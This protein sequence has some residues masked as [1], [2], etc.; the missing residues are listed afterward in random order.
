[1]RTEYRS[2][3]NSFIPELAKP[4]ARTAYHSVRGASADARARFMPTPVTT[5]CPPVF[6]IGCGRSGT[7]LLGELIAMHQRVKYLHEPHDLWAAVHP[8]TDFLQLYKNGEYHCMLDS[9]LVTGEMRTRFQRLMLPRRGFTLVEKSP[10][11]ALRLGFLDAI[12]PSARFVHIVRDGIEVAQSIERIASATRSMAFRPP[13]NNWW[14]INDSKWTA[15]VHD[16]TAAGYYPDEV[17]QL[18]TDAYRGAYEWILSVR[19]IDAWRSRLGSRL[20][21]LRLE[22]LIDEPRRTLKPV[23][24]WLGLSLSDERW[25][26]QASKMVHPLTNDY[27]TELELPDEM[28]VDFNKFQESYRFKGRATETTSALII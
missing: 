2:R 1:M 24:D 19:E 18:T 9:R 16:G 7:T 10:V 23:V 15:L 6:I 4:L 8:A 12:A 28:R 3:I 26:D 17:S 5:A 11:N 20:I 27:K 21:E 13:L 25:L 22:D 14:G